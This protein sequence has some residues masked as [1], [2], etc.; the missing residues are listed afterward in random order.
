[1]YEVEEKLNVVQ[2]TTLSFFPEWQLYLPELSEYEKQ[3]L[4]RSR[5]DFLSL[6]KYPLHE[7]VVKLSILAPLLSLAGLLRFPFYPQAEA[8]IKIA[9]KVMEA[10]QVGS[11]V[12]GFAGGVWAGEDTRSTREAEKY[13]LY[14]S[15]SKVIR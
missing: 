15:V 12:G 13:Y 9:V 14:E 6:M 4:D 2:I 7:E 1:M 5:D 11:L 8:D 10:R 3:C